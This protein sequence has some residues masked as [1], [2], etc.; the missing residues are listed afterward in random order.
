MVPK[1]ACNRPSDAPRRFSSR[2]SLSFAFPRLFPCSYNP[3]RHFP[4][5]GCHGRGS[6][7]RDVISR[8]RGDAPAVQLRAGHREEHRGH[9]RRYRAHIP[10]YE[11]AKEQHG[12]QGKHGRAVQAASIGK[13]KT[14]RAAFHTPKVR[15]ATVRPSMKVLR[16]ASAEK[17]GMFSQSLVTTARDERAYA[18][19]YIAPIQAIT[20]EDEGDLP[21]RRGASAARLDKEGD[22]QAGSSEE[23]GRNKNRARGPHARAQGSISHARLLN[24]TIGEH[25]VK[26]LNCE[27][28]R[29]LRVVA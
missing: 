23:Q 7:R 28:M 9:G 8:H 27:I 5:E 1:N 11:L 20:G 26:P 3:Q 18:E 19:P 2:R 13:A 29:K 15:S 25:H 14:E 21:N 17:S 16:R 12:R 10:I 6:G 24:R 4:K 22:A